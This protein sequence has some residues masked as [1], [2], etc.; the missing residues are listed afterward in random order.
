MSQTDEET[1]QRICEEVQGEM[2]VSLQ[3]AIF[4]A[5]AKTVARRYAE[6]VGVGVPIDGNLAGVFRTNDPDLGSDSLEAYCRGGKL[7]V[8]IDEPWAGDTETGFGQT[9][10]VGLNLD[11]AEKLARWILATIKLER[12]APPTA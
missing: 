9:C 6:T 5:F 4:T 11:E 10:S 3:S 12:E 1:L 7:T 2:G 8:Q